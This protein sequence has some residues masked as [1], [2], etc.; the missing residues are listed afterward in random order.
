MDIQKVASVASR[1]DVIRQVAHRFLQDW[2]QKLVFVDRLRPSESLPESDRGVKEEETSWVLTENRIYEALIVLLRHHGENGSV[3]LIEEPRSRKIV[4]FGPGESL[5]MDV[6]FIGLSRQEVDR[7]Y[8][9]FAKLGKEY[10]IEYAA[11]DPGSDKV[12]HGTAFNHDF[13]QDAR[14]AARAA[15]SFFRDVYLFSPDEELTIEQR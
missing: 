6:P 10:L 7:G 5:E 8:Q 15:V 13:G 1:L 14:A 11:P 3:V 2:R 12:C 4:H 9:F